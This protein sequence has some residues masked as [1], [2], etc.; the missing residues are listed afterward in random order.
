MQN[1]QQQN[2]EIEPQC[3]TITLGS[4]ITSAINGIIGVIA[5]YLF[6]PVL[7]KI[8]QTWKKKDVS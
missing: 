8:T 1:S 5:A 7:D 3:V 6:K 4:V 2:D